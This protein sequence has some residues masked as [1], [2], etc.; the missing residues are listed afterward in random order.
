VDVVD[1]RGELRFR[2]VPVAL[3]EEE[4]PE[5]EAELNAF[6]RWSMK[7]LERFAMEDEKGDG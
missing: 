7:N 6:A 4:D 5:V 3:A 1:E 2:L